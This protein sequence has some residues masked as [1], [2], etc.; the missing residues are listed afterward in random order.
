MDAGAGTAKGRAGLGRGSTPGAVVG[1]VVE[2]SQSPIALR[3][4][5][6]DRVAATIVSASYLLGAAGAWY[7]TTVLL[8]HLDP[9]RYLVGIT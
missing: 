5:Q 6:R 7:E 8:G 4:R 3:P 1:H 9:G 2:G